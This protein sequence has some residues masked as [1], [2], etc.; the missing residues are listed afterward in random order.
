MLL[1]KKEKMLIFKTT[2]RFI[3]F[4]LLGIFL[5][6]SFSALIAFLNGRDGSLYPLLISAGITLVVAIACV[7]STKPNRRID[8]KTGFSIVTGCWVAAC[9]FGALPFVLYGHEFTFVNALFES[10]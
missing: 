3:G 2:L 10:V 4:A 1:S 7:L 5:L 6:M 9:L 8:L